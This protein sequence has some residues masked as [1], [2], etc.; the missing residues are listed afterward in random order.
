MTIPLDGYPSYRPY[1]NITPF[2]FRDG[3]TYL[4]QLEALKD[5]IRDSLVPLL[6]A[7]VGG[8]TDDWK[9]LTTQLLD[10]FT[11]KTEALQQLVTDSVTDMSGQVDL[12]QAA[13]AAA[14][15]ARDLAAVY[16][17]TIE[18]VQDSA[19]TNIFNDFNSTFRQ[20]FNAIASTLVAEDPNDEGTFVIGASVPL[21][22][23]NV[24]EDPNDPGFWI[25][26]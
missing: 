12:A 26:E 15:S 9:A 18:T 21:E 11:S 4:L 7:E 24:T 23:L 5:W 14:E 6:D 13:Q 3:A 16:A 17:S 1:S 19:I 8:L 25:E 10:D 20:T 2:T 22:P